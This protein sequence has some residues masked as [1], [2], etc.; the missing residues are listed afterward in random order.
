M[1]MNTTVRQILVGTSCIVA[2]AAIGAAGNKLLDLS[3]IEFLGGKTT[4]TI[5]AEIRDSMNNVLPEHA[6]ILVASGDGCPIGWVSYSEAAGRFVVGVGSGK[7]DGKTHHSFDFGN[8]GGHYRHTLTEPE[9]PAHTHRLFVGQSD[10]SHLWGQSDRE[11][12]TQS[13]HA[14]DGWNLG[15]YQRSAELR[16]LTEPA[17]TGADHI[18]LP[19][20][21]PLYLCRQGGLLK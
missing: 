8:L 4:K 13:T 19:P 16:Q 20:Y 15:H 2:A 11:S 3:L 10:R 6:I 14:F 18:H 1:P 21:V 5:E 12:K 9:L 7:D 17:G